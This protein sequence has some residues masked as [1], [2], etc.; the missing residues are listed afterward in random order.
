MIK[1]HDFYSWQNW[2]NA[3]EIQR[4]AESLM[5]Y[6]VPWNIPQFASNL[7]E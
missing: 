6:G 5:C 4:T 1:A 7:K 3:V 2:E